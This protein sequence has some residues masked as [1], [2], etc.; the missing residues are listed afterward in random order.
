MMDATEVC[1]KPRAAGVIC[2]PTS[3]PNGVLDDQAWLFLDFLKQSG[4]T[5]WQL[6]PLTEPVH[7]LSP[8][9][10]TSA[11]AMNP[12]LLPADWQTQLDETAFQSFMASPPFWLVDYALFVTLR[13]HFEQQSWSHWPEVYRKRQPD[14]LKEFSL[15]HEAELTHIY[16]QQFS[17]LT[18][19][20]RLKQDANDAGIQLF[21]DMPIFVAYD[22][23]D[24]WCNPQQFKLDDLGQPTVVAGVPP[25][26]FSATGQLWGN[27]HYDWEVMAKDGFSWWQAR[28]AESLKLFDLVRI[29]HFRALDACWEVGAEETTAINGHWQPVPGYALLKTLHDSF[30]CLP[31][32]AEDLG[33]ITP[34]VVALKEAFN[35]PGMSV[36]Q[37]GFN[38]L[39][40]NPHSLAEQVPLSVT[41]SG[42]HDNQTTLGWWQSIT[43]EGQKQWILSQLP[44]PEDP[45]PWPI[46]K[47]GMASVATQFIA[48]LQDYLALD[49]SARMNVPGTPTGNWTWR[50]SWDQFDPNLA[51]KILALVTQTNRK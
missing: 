42:T 16:Q 26:Y 35:L 5:I 41:Y 19:W 30:G 7:E 11:F 15:A 43:D 18:I 1:Q 48:P 47:A 3:L 10:S 27:P 9:Q 46:I 4:L 44:N 34:E 38:G 21:G 49:D 50:F 6:L 31:L 17:M 13:Q 40:D 2:H 33:V 29:D 36:L 32:V 14:A 12:A 51:E 8:Y 25:D 45:M 20:H 23:A 28:V 22:S 39:P 24:V 37:F